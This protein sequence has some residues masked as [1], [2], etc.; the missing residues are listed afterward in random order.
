MMV[1]SG[2]D[3]L[4]VANSYVTWNR[5]KAVKLRMS[6]T[7]PQSQPPVSVVTAFQ[8]TLA[9]FPDHTAIGTCFCFQ[10]YTVFRKKW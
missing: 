5:E 6:E 3:A 7:G 2:P 9:R 4:A 10:N 8:Q 1:W